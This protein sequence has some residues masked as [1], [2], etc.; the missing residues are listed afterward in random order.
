MKLSEKDIDNIAQYLDTGMICY[1]N[2]ETGEVREMLNL[3]EVY[4]CREHWEESLNEIKR[5]WKDYAIIE[6][7]SSREAFDIMRTFA[8]SLPSSGIKSKLFNA[9]EKKGPFRNFKHIVDNGGDI[10]E[11]WFAHK[12]RAYRNY[13]RYELK[14]DFEIDFSVEDIEETTGLGLSLDE[15]YLSAEGGEIFDGATNPSTY[16]R[17]SQTDNLVSAT[18]DGGGIIIGSIIGHVKERKLHFTYQ[19]LTSDNSFRSGKGTG[20]IDA[21]KLGNIELTIVWKS[22]NE[23]GATGVVT[24]YQ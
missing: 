4:D 2:R 20:K 21:D 7:M 1:L 22:N 8:E 23:D 14:N 3:D 18:Y 19:G 12:S 6:K 16:F 24:L 9:L 11:Q 15:R 13:V 17:F 10:R 5:D